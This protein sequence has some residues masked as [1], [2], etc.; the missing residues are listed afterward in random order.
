MLAVA[1]QGLERAGA[2]CIGL[3]HEYDATSSPRRFSRH[4]RFRACHI[5][6]ATRNRSAD[7]ESARLACSARALHDGESTSEPAGC[8]SSTASNVTAAAPRRAQRRQQTF[9]DERA[10][11]SALPVPFD[12]VVAK[13]NAEVDTRQRAFHSRCREALERP[14]W[15]VHAHFRRHRPCAVDFAYFHRE[16]IIIAEGVRE[17]GHGGA[18][19]SSMRRWIGRKRIGVSVRVVPLQVRLSPRIAVV[20]SP[21]DRGERAPVVVEELAVERTD[22]RIDDAHV[23]QRKHSRRTPQIGAA[24]SND[25]ACEPIVR[26]L[27]ELLPPQRQMGLVLRT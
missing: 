20:C 9:C 19:R 16:R 24:R 4:V 6:D 23:E 10:N 2:D 17:N 26:T 11:L 1:A 25:L 18:A 14:R 15:R 8:A 22:V 27:H 7:R 5:A 21:P 13:V 12:R 3:M